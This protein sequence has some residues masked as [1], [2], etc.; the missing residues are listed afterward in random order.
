MV[1]MSVYLQLRAWSCPKRQY[2]AL[3]GVPVAFKVKPPPR[4]GLSALVPCL[5]VIV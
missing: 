3:L 2:H 5:C 1:C 4:V